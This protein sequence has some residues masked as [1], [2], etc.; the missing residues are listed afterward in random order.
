MNRIEFEKVQNA[1][2]VAHTDV[3]AP[4]AQLAL[5]QARAIVANAQYTGGSSVAAP[6]TCPPAG[7]QLD[8]VHPPACGDYITPLMAPSRWL[9][10]PNI[11]VV[12]P[13]A[14]SPGVVLRFSAGGGWL[15]GWRGS[16]IDFTAGAFRADELTRATLQLQMRLND[17]EE[18]ITNGQGLDFM[19]LSDVF[20]PGTVISPIMRRVD[21]KDI[22]TVT[23]RN[24][25]PAGGA[26]LTPTLAFS[27]WR[28][29]YPGTG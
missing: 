14:T 6:S 26:I 15:I 10:V 20:P 19:S 3:R 16:S 27:F 23:W 11:P 5:R 1:L 24:I 4:E 9:V 13:Q 12:A 28:E 18:L 8:Q 2:A 17:G 22:L 21:V 29:K 7:Y 25:Q